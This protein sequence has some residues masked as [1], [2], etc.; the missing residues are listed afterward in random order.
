MFNHVTRRRLA[1]IAMMA[2]AAFFSAISAPALAEGAG[3]ELD[4]GSA[5]K[6]E[7]PGWAGNVAFG[8][9]GRS[10]NSDNTSISGELN[11]SYQTVGDWL[12]DGRFFG[13][14]KTEDSTTTDERYDAN[15]AAKWF[16]SDIDYLVGRVSYR[17]DNFAG[18]RQQYMGTAGYGRV[19]FNTKRQNLTGEVGLGMRNTED[20]DGS[21][22]TNPVAVGGLKYGLKISENADFGQLLVV[23][24]GT[25]N[26]VFR[27]LS[28]LRASIIGALAG[29]A[30]FEIIR[31]S[32]VSPDTDKADYYTIVGLE[33]SF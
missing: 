1:V 16:M 31:N 2:Q 21:S 20:Q 19:L 18:V 9:S 7:E 29:K 26:T 10:G 8:Y 4:F 3:A 14:G 6:K 22:D 28:E 12:Y 15:A 24:Y 5:G 25:D 23:E 30:S 17:K 13:L 32:S 11:W 33:Y 27:S